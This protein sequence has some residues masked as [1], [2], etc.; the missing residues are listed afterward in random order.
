[1]TITA[2]VFSTGRL[3]LFTSVNE[4]FKLV[5]GSPSHLVRLPRMVH[6]RPD[7]CQFQ[8]LGSKVT[9]SIIGV[10][11]GPE[12]NVLHFKTAE[13]MTADGGEQNILL[14]TLE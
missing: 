5:V 7:D 4:R 3:R 11:S 8:S 14:L 1:M 12:V 10:H 2:G 13:V 6:S 9:F